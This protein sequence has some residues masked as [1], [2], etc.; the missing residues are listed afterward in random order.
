MGTLPVYLPKS[1]RKRL[2]A[3]G[4]R[5]NGAENPAGSRCVKAAERC[6]GLASWLLSE[7]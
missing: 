1:A 6:G 2:S 7:K 4:T 5:G 3:P